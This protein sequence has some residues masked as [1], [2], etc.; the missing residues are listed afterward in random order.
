MPPL[1][2]LAKRA[3]I[4]LPVPTPPRQTVNLG[5]ITPMLFDGVPS[6]LKE[7]FDRLLDVSDVYVSNGIRPGE[8]PAIL[9]FDGF[10]GSWKTP[11]EK[12]LD[13]YFEYV[14]N[15][16]P[17]YGKVLD[18]FEM[19]PLHEDVRQM[20]TYVTGGAGSGK[21]ELLKVLVHHDLTAGNAAVVIDP[22]GNFARSVAEWPEFAGSGRERLVYINPSIRPGFA[23]ALNPLD[24]SGLSMEG[25]EAL[26][27]SLTDVLSQVGGRGEWSAQAETIA[28]NCFKVLV[29]QPGATLRDLRLAMVEVDKRAK[30]IPTPVKAMQEAGLRHYNREVRDFFEYDFLSGQY[31]SSR[32]SLRAKIG[33]LL[34]DDLFE[35]I[36]CQPSK[37][38]LEELVD[39]RKII[40]FDLGAWGDAMSAG[41]F[42]RM[43]VA[44]LSA[45]GMRRSMEYGTDKT[46]VH[47]FVDE[48]DMFVSPAMLF[49]LSKLRQH[50]VHLTL[51]QQTPGYGYHGQDVEQLLI[52]TAIKFAAGSGQGR[53]MKMMGLPSETTTGLKQGEFIGQWGRGLP[54]KIAVRS[55]LIGRAMATNEWEDV[56]DHQVAAYYSPIAQ[57][58]MPLTRPSPSQIADAPGREL[59]QQDNTSLSPAEKMLEAPEES[60]WPE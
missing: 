40:V 5:R 18:G 35:A 24:G 13:G 53:M 49:M 38:S 20:H 41:A 19:T 47:V 46:P 37:I 48:A 44:Q 59:P 23:P 15:K 14:R 45:L 42:G 21:T 11:F 36:T 30:E 32:S 50:G 60:E 28:H 3:G 34:R 4:N 27:K 57:P 43:V 2:V 55:D 6:S 39:A 12:T 16:A 10:L 8:G 31:S 51:A 26:A 29:H 54:F 58:E 22:Q 17:A 33:G 1:D 25:R 56:L 52:N 9:G 7:L